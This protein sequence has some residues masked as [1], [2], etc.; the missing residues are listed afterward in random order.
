VLYPDLS[1]SALQ[2]VKSIMLFHRKPLNELDGASIALTT[3]SAT[4]VNLLKIILDKGY[5]L[6]PNYTSAAPS[7]TDMMQ[8]HDAA[9]LIG[10]DAIKATW[11]DYGYL[12]TDLGEEWFKLTGKWMTFAVWAIRKQVLDSDPEMIGR[13]YEAFLESKRKSLKDPA[14]LIADAQTKIGGTEHY[15]EQYFGNLCYDFGPNQ[16][17]GL[18]LFYDYSYELGLLPRKV[19]LKIWQHNSVVQVT[20]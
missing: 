16:W 5:G 12:V 8:E 4:S 1:V 14:G 10:D 18:Q 11:V 9:L 17:A 2:S 15:W 7:L 20:G 13:I 3:A 19:Q 6:K